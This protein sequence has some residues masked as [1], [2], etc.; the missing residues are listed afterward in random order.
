LVKITLQTPGGPLDP[1]ELG[2]GDSLLVGRKPDTHPA[3]ERT[4][5]RQM[6]AVPLSS[7]SGN[8]VLV[9][10]DGASTRL[11]DLGSKNGTWL[12]LPPNLGVQVPAN[13]ALSV[14]LALPE[15]VTRGEDQPDDASWTRPEDFAQSVVRVLEEWLDCRRLPVRLSLTRRLATHREPEHPGQI[16]LAV[17]MDLHVVPLRTMEAAWPEL[18]SQVWRYVMRQNDLFAI[19]QE[20]RQEGIIL[21]SPVM[22]RVYRSVVEAARRGLRVLIMGPSGAGKEALARC[23]HRHSGRSGAFVARNCAMMSKEFLRAELFGAERGSFTGSVQRI[24]GAVER[25]NAGTLFLDEVGELP[26]D[27]QPM[28]LRFLDAGEY[29]RLGQFG[30]PCHADVRVV[31]ATNKDLRAACASGEFRTDLWFRLSIQVI[32]VPPLRERLED[33]EAYLKT[34]SINRDASAYDLLSPEAVELVRAHAWEGNFRELANFAERLPR[35]AAQGSISAARCRDALE[36]GSLVPVR[37]S[38]PALTPP[39]GD[40]AWSDLAQ[41]AAGAFGEDHAD[42]VPQTWDDVKEYIEKYLKPLL[43]AHLS[44]VGESFDASDIRVHADRMSADRATATKQ[45]ERYLDRFRK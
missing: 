24:T 21:A 29:E 11:T 19:E 39:S 33:V 37:S 32:E 17:S 43:F 30:S 5:R 7:V 18:L 10:S 44:G 35:D 31:C 8:H 42:Q 36:Q 12:K 25:A 27:V 45:I 15:S 16:P 40:D 13:E 14:Y 22:R 1:V 38:R 3:S 34:F 20:L 28:L 23:Y 4:E 2:P 9:A 26:A 41:R 6:L